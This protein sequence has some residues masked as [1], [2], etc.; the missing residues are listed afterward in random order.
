MI[1]R[2]A[3]CR[4]PNIHRIFLGRLLIGATALS[5][6]AAPAH[7]FDMRVLADVTERMEF[8]DNLQ[9]DPDPDGDVF[10][11]TTTFNL[12]VTARTQTSTLNVRGGANL[13]E[14]GG[15]GA[16][17]D[18]DTFNQNVKG[19]FQL[20]GPR[21]TVGVDASFARSNTAF[22]EFEDVNFGGFDQT[23]VTEGSTDRLSYSVGGDVT[24]EVNRTNKL[25]GS[26]TYSAVDF[27]ESV[28]DLTPTDR[29]AFNA[30]WFR[31]LTE[32][33][34]LKTSGSL[35]FFNSDNASQSE[36][37]TI[38]LSTRITSEL[39]PN[40]TVYGEGG[41]NIITTEQLS[42][43]V[44]QS[45]TTVG[46]TF[47]FGLTYLMWLTT[48]FTASVSQ[49]VSPSDSGNLNQR[50]GVNASLSHRI[51]TVSSF[52]TGAT[53]A[54]QESATSGPAGGSDNRNFV[55]FFANYSVQIA[56]YW[57]FALGYDLRVNDQDTGTGVSNKIFGTLSREFVLL[58]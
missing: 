28:G 58:P 37:R 33:T 7:A 39:T 23:I 8:D 18:L 2:H 55:R 25:S 41:I 49:S 35:S 34:D 9:V 44:R 43:G 40:L 27:A 26:V 13:R 11:S 46:N 57:N 17:S 1:H 53:Y 16:T 30:S 10:G 14:F 54:I 29:L 31:E 12:D 21:T 22:T 45:E 47:D 6:C 32:T 4:D 5:L 51:N 20:E 3:G 50:T 24:V 36:N 48:T 15:P 42:A 52:S 56:R 38:A 19:D